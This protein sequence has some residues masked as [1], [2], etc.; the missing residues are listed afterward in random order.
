MRRSLFAQLVV[1][2]LIGA[3]VK[4]ILQGKAP[5]RSLVSY[6][7]HLTNKNLLGVVVGDVIAFLL[8]SAVYRVVRRICASPMKANC[9][10]LAD[11]S[12]SVL[13]SLPFIKG[14]V[15]AEMEKH[16]RDLASSV[17]PKGIEY[18]PQLP[19]SGMS[20]EEIIG[21]MKA[22]VEKEKGKWEEGRLSGGVYHG[23]EEHID[24][25][26]VASSLYAISNPLHIDIWPSL[27]KFES[28]IIKMT[29]NI[30]CGTCDTVCGS[31][32]SG[33]TESIILA[34][35]AHK[36][37]G[38][39]RGITNPELIACVTAH[40]AVNKA[41][42]MLGIHLITV[43][44]DPETFEM[45]VNATRRAISSDT[46]MIYSSAPN[47]PSGIVDPIEKLSKLAKKYSVG[48][49]VDCCL[50]GFILPFGKEAGFDVPSFD[51]SNPGVTSMS[52]DTHKYGYAAKGSS[53]V[54]YRNKELRR[55]QYFTYPKWTGGLYATTTIAG[56]RPG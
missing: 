19:E 6:L 37:A 29:A 13:R 3:H 48:L 24:L 16:E 41:C 54:L 12:Y 38:E 20:R 36:A 8:L 31:M 39:A 28:D 5:R 7:T 52:V 11:W 32:T 53:V 34:I 10:A 43:P 21:V 17:L 30:V 33:G 50:G 1:C 22:F 49:H 47:Y 44:F 25:M 15:E 35:R 27:H 23:G 40:A 46:I 18:L 26:N 45:D 56:S 9:E 42:E 55:H 4:K 14:S 51:F 2:G